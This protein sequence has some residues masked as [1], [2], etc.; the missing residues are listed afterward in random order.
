MD[1]TT[2][3]KTTDENERNLTLT[4]SRFLDIDVVKNQFA[5]HLKTIDKMVETA[6]THEVVDDTTVKEGVAMAGDSKKLYKKI[7]TQRK[8]IIEQPNAFVKSV[9]NFCKEFTKPLNL[10]EQGL[11]RKIG[12]YQYKVELERRKQEEEIRKA[13]EKLQKKL[14]AEAKKSGVEAPTVAPAPLP[15]QDTVARADTGAAAHT[16][17]QWKGEIIDA[18]KI[19]REYCSPDMKKINEAIKMGTR[20]IPGVKVFEE[21]STVLRT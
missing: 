10:L 5:K 2:V 7:E 17:K 1:F 20:T 9:N 12:D 3:G 4:E 13:N 14:N 19:P 15:K 18:E 11:K 8:E 16:R 21:I 6:E